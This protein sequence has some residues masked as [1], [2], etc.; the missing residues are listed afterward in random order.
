ML[1]TMILTTVVAVEVVREVVVE[2][3]FLERD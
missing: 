1:I 3:K 2:S